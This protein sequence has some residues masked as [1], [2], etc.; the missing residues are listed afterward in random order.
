[1]LDVGEKLAVEVTTPLLHEYELAPAAVCVTVEPTQTKVLPVTEIVGLG[2]TLIVATPLAKP[3][4]P[5]SP[6][7]TEYV[8]LIVGETIMLFVFAPLF[9]VNVFIPPA[10]IVAV[11]PEQIVAELTITC[12][13][14]VTATCVV[15]VFEQPKLEVPEIV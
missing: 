3:G 9:Q 7:F 2:L 1:M 13:D 5:V 14:V 8:V 15:E 10:I 6:P 12:G 4:Q 11:F